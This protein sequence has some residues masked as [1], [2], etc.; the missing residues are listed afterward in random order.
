VLDTTRSM[1]FRE[2][3]IV[4]LDSPLEFPLIGYSQSL[5]GVSAT[6]VA[7]LPEILKPGAAYLFME[8]RQTGAGVAPPPPGYEGMGYW[9]SP[10]LFMGQSVS[11]DPESAM[12]AKHLGE[13]LERLFAP[14][15]TG[16]KVLRFYS[17]NI[18]PPVTARS[19]AS[20]QH[21]AQ[22]TT[23]ASPHLR[24]RSTPRTCWVATGTYRL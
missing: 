18:A 23:S 13:Q 4:S 1:P 21:S 20:K 6:I 12:Q 11:P 7:G 19:S 17:P 10:F 8:L 16:T 14:D 9:Q 24:K 2:I 5:R 3:G 22:T 15:A